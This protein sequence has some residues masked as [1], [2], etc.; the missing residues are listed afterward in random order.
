MVVCNFNNEE[1]IKKNIKDY[2]SFL[3]ALDECENE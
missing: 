3:R 2:E 1:R